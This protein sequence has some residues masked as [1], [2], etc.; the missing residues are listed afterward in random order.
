MNNFDREKFEKL[1]LKKIDENN[2]GWIKH[3]IK[4]NAEGIPQI[5]F[6]PEQSHLE[7]YGM[8]LELN[9]CIDSCADPRTRKPKHDA[10]SENKTD[11]R[12]LK[13]RSKEAAETAVSGFVLMT[14]PIWISAMIVLPLFLLGK[15]CGW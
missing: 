15:A 9:K 14:S 12:D 6:D 1:W 4:Y 3:K 7:N 13:E 8:I 10:H 11:E 2:W 5:T